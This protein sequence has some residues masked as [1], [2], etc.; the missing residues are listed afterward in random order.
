MLWRQDAVSYGRC[1][2]PARTSARVRRLAGREWFAELDST[3]RYAARRGPG[4]RR[5]GPGRGRRPPDRRAGPAWAGRGRRR[6]ARRCWS[7]VLLRPAAARS[8]S[9]C[10]DG[11]RGGAWPTR[12]SAVAGVDAELK[13][14]NDLVVGDRKLAGLLAEAEGDAVVVGA[15]CNV[16]WR[17]VS[18][19]SC[20]DRR[21]PATSR[22]V[23]PSTA[24]PCSTPSSTALADGARRP[25][26]ACRL[27]A[28]RARLATLGRRVRVEHVRGD[29]LVGSRGRRRRR[30]R[31]RRARRRRHRAHR[32]RRR[33]RPPPRPER[34]GAPTP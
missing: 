24:T 13:W 30:R 14:P 33:R 10:R 27:E 28:Y 2:N 22:P 25:V 7:S 8:P 34:F 26:D 4:G 1:L 18:R 31:P 11:G 21:P 3:N 6:R 29:D 17:V 20:A 9:R 15:G 5:R 32:R 16:D 23:A 19:R 12:S